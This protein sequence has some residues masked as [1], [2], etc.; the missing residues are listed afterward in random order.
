MKGT[1]LQRRIAAAAFSLVLGSVLAVPSAPARATAPGTEGVELVNVASGLS[2]PTD[3]T[4]PPGDSRVFIAEKPGRIRI[5]E[6]GTLLSTPFL[7]ITGLILDGSERGLLGIAFHPDYSENG[8]FYVS[9]S[10][11]GSG[12]SKIVEYEVSGSPNR[13]DTGSAR[14]I[15]TV[16]QPTTNHNGG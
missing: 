10:A 14:T 4:A 12:A 6:N 3:L 9:Y 2:T 1:L 15:L 8:L 11:E 13:A 7:D 5:V 16:S